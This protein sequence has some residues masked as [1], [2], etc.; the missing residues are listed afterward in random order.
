M[1][2]F[3]LPIIFNKK[4]P[5]P[6]Y[7]DAPMKQTPHDLVATAVNQ[8]ADLAMVEKLMDLRDRWEAAEAKKAYTQAITRFKAECPEIFKDQIVDYKHKTGGGS[9]NYAYE[10]LP[11]LLKTI[12]PALSRYDL[13]ISW[14]TDQSEAA[15]KVT[16]FITHALGHFESTALFGP[17]DKSGNKNTVQAIASTVSYL[18]RYTCKA[19]LGLASRDMDDDSHG[20][21]PGNE[22]EAIAKDQLKRINAIVKQKQPNDWEK[23]LMKQYGVDNVSKLTKD[24]AA[25]CLQLIGG[26]NA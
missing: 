2:R 6:Q 15:I 16:C 14:K 12:T 20:S 26:E 3:S 4:E 19:L 7:S 11:N 1:K 9:T 24:Q 22:P 21:E 5:S 13:S 17:P 23:R 18:E 25:S 8:G 10:S